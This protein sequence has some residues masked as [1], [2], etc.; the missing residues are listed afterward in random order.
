MTLKSIVVQLT[1]DNQEVRGSFRAQVTAAGTDVLILGDKKS[2]MFFKFDNIEIKSVTIRHVGKEYDFKTKKIKSWIKCG[3]EQIL[4]ETYTPENK[5]QAYF[6][7]TALY[8]QH[9]NEKSIIET[10]LFAVK[11][12][13]TITNLDCPKETTSYPMSSPL[14]PT[15]NSDNRTGHVSTRTSGKTYVYKRDLEPNLHISSVMIDFLNEIIEGR[16]YERKQNYWEQ[17]YIGQLMA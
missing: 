3:E 6:L 13:Y 9:K 7:L 16:D 12:H 2:S 17:G 4:I 5:Q 15:L 8:I 1:T 11:D 10:E 14:N